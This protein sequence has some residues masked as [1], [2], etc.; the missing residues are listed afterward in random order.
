MAIKVTWYSI[1]S[2]YAQ[3]WRLLDLSG[4]TKSVRESRNFTKA[5][6]VYV[7]G[8]L[9]N[10]LKATVPLGQNLVLSLHFPNGKIKSKE[11]MVIS[12]ATGR[13]RSR[14]TGPMVLHYNG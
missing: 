2:P 8:N 3:V 7:D 10:S 4:L 5:G 6:Y 12:R 11:I 1:V 14:Q 13:K 9:V